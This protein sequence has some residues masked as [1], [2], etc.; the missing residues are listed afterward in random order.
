MK[1]EEL[2]FVSV[3]VPTYNRPHYAARCLT[4]VLANKYETF[5]VIVV[6][7]SSN[8]DTRWEIEK[9]AADNDRIHYVHSNVVGVSHARNLALSLAKGEIIALIDDDA[10]ATPNWIEAYAHTFQALNPP[11]G[12]IGGKIDPLWEVP[13][14]AWY[15]AQRQ[16][17]LGIYD[18]GDELCPF[19]VGDLP[20]SANFAVLKAVIESIGGFDTRIGFNNKHSHRLM[21]GEDSL[22]GLKIQEQGYSIYYQPEARVLHSVRESKLRRRFFLN[23]HFWEGATIVAIRDLQDP[24]QSLTLKGNIRCHGKSIPHKF[25][26]CCVR[27]CRRRENA[28]RNSCSTLPN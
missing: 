1:S 24:G 26:S 22:V 21:T 11:P 7:Q 28:S 15:P 14:P 23:R 3:I 5:E 4:S 13:R 12:I 8:Q 6:D 25:S 10:V 19:P 16:F 20:I 9:L 2:P 17:L 18:I 27:C